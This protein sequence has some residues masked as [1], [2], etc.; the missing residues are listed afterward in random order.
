MISIKSLSK[1]FENKIVFKNLSFSLEKEK[2][3]VILGPSGC[4]KSTLLNIIGG[5]D[6]D[7]QG[8]INNPHNSIS[9][10]F[11]ED[12]LLPW[13]TVEENIKYVLNGNKYPKDLIDFLSLGPL[14]NTLIKYLSGGQK[15]RVA[16][17]RAFALKSSL[18]LM[19]ENLKSLDLNLKLTL[20][21]EINTFKSFGIDNIIYV[22]HD[23]EEALLLADKVIILNEH[24]SII[25][26]FIIDVDKERRYSNRD[27]LINYEMIIYKSFGLR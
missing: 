27:L 13:L 17:A 9:Y 2:I 18:V 23:I 16:I 3:L 12:R 25:N 21:K 4:G 6:L 11:Q 19:D 7:Y 8:E 10:V 14:E 26:S 1:S 20:I 15:Q 24:G 5:I 22:T